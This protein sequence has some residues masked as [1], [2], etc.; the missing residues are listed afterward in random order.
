M[1]VGL[2]D[3]PLSEK[4]QKD[5]WQ[6]QGIIR[7]EGLSASNVDRVKS[8]KPKPEMK[9]YK[10]TQADVN[11]HIQ[12]FRHCNCKSRKRSD[13]PGKHSICNRCKR[14]GHW[15]KCCK[16]RKMAGIKRDDKEF[17]FGEIYIDKLENLFVLKKSLLVS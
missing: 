8:V 1:I 2:K 5:L 6:Q 16:T 7:Q 17:F 15:E 12:K 4:L 13:C 14:K 11:D 9:H 3:K 10:H